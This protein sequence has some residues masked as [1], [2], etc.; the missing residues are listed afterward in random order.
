MINEY[1]LLKQGEKE[2]PYTH[3]EI[4][5]MEIEAYQLILSP[6]ADDWQSAIDMPEFEEYFKSLGIFL[7][8]KRNVANFGWRLLAY[9]IDYVILILL[10]AIIGGLVGVLE[11]LTSIYINSDNENEI[12]I[13]RLIGVIMF[14][15]YHSGFEST[16]IQGS[17]GKAL[18]KLIVV[19]ING[20]RIKFGRALV[21]NLSKILSG[22]FFGFGFFNIL[23]ST[24]KQGWHDEL[25]KTYIVRKINY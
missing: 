10:A 4:M 18:C 2:G 24:L 21:R 8:D 15:L 22:L 19:D 25:A 7:P 3:I 1:Y 20:R 16:K 13:T 5:D 17:I 14:I 9:I 23:W 11:S 6:L 12:W